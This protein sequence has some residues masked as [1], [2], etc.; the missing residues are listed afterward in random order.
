MLLADTPAKDLIGH[1]NFWYL[2]WI[3]IGK[4]LKWVPAPLEKNKLTW[5][6][7]LVEMG[8]LTNIVDLKNGPKLMRGKFPNPLFPLSYGRLILAS[9]TPGLLIEEYDH[10][11]P[12]EQTPL[13]WMEQ[14][15]H[16][17]SGDQRLNF[18]INQ[19]FELIDHR[20]DEHSTLYKHF[21][22]GRLFQLLILPNETLGEK[23]FQQEWVFSEISHPQWAYGYLQQKHRKK[24]GHNDMIATD[25]LQM[26]EEDKAGLPC[27][28]EGCHRQ[29][30]RHSSL[31]KYHHFEAV[32]GIAPNVE[33]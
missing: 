32:M 28:Q 25:Y 26:L 15:I 19:E 11:L 14:E 30:I 17:K 23:I 31:C 21:K 12:F 3:H 8:H 29:R 5:Q 22:N 27:Q 16:V 2:P 1:N 9:Q 33:E 24:R 7:G 4:D 20:P 18:I 10:S 6:H 13:S